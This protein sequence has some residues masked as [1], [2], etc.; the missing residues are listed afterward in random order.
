MT[1][2]V[3][4][5]YDF[6]KEGYLHLLPAN[7]KNSKVPGDDAMMVGAR[8]AFLVAGHYQPLVQ[9]VKK[10]IETKYKDM[11]PLAALDIGCGNGYYTHESIENTGIFEH[12]Y[13]IDISKYAVRQAAKSHKNMHF[14]V[15]SA[16]DIPIASNSMDLALSVFAPISPAEVERILKGNGH[17]VVVTPGSQ[18]LREL[19]EIIY[20]R[21]REHNNTTHDRL[22]TNLQLVKSE[23]ISFNIQLQTED[24]ITNLLK[25]TPYYWN[26]DRDKLKKIR[27]LADLQVTCHF[28]ID[29]F[30]PHKKA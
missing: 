21:Y 9:A 30:A 29:I 11:E 15:G 16:F 7:K 22:S 24:D 12:I 26:K 17:F 27:L 14:F 2:S 13:G 10:I 1:C 5:N 6:T 25:M 4:H 8:S 18:H 23:D 3:G 20:D 19:A 28:Q